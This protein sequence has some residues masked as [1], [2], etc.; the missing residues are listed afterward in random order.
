MPGTPESRGALGGGSADP[1]ASVEGWGGTDR[2]TW[3]VPA[4]TAWCARSQSLG[5]FILQMDWEPGSKCPSRGA[6]RGWL[7]APGLGAA[8]SGAGRQDGARKV[9]RSHRGVPTVESLAEVPSLGHGS[10]H[11]PWPRGGLCRGCHLAV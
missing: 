10:G 1:Q 9:Q 5:E 7:R 4:V 8:E 6:C 2:R 3:P 11:M